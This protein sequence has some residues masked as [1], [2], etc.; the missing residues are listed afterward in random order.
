M[1]RG[2]AKLWPTQTL[3][4]SHAGGIPGE[5]GAAGPRI[6]LTAAR[7]GS[8]C[9]VTAVPDVAMCTSGMHVLR[10]SPTLKQL[11]ALFAP[12]ATAEASLS[13]FA[14][15]ARLQQTAG[16][17]RSGTRIILTPPQLLW[18]A[19]YRST[20]GGA[21]QA[22]GTQ[23]TRPHQEIAVR[24]ALAA[25]PAGKSNIES[26]AMAAWQSSDLTWRQNGLLPGMEGRQA[27]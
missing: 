2:A 13:G 22:G 12:F 26:S 20:H 6:S 19:I 24:M 25:L 23:T 21:Q 27:S 15:A 16:Y 17:C 10:P 3:T 4:A 14:A 7:N 11:M 1:G 5:M 8:G 9:S 18:P